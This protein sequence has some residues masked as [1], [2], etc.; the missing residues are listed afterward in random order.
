ML[1]FKFSKKLF[2]L[3]AISAGVLAA[4][5]YIYLKKKR[6]V[7]ELS[8]L[9]ANTD[10]STGAMS[11]NF[12]FDLETTDGLSG[13]EN[14]KQSIAHSGKMACNLGGGKEF[15][16]SVVRKLGDVGTFPIKRTAASI[17]IYPLSE[18]CNVVLTASISNSKNEGVFWDGKSTERMELP[19]NTWTKL[20][21]LYNFPVEKLN[22]DDV[23]QI[24]IWNKGKTD[25]IVDD[26]EVVYGESTERRG[27]HSMVDANLFYEKLFVGQRNKPPFPVIPFKK[28]EINNSDSTQLIAGNTNIDLSP[29]DEYLVGDFIE[30]KNNLDEL[31]YFKD[32][33]TFILGYSS[34]KEK[35]QILQET[36]NIIKQTAGNTI[37]KKFA[38]DFNSDGRADVLIINKNKWQLFELK[39]KAWNSI[40]NGNNG[41]LKADWFSD[42]NKSF[43]SDLFSLNNKDVLVQTNSSDYY[44]LQFNKTSGALEETKSN[45]S[46]AD[47]GLFNATSFI[48]PGDFTGR[49]MEELL[50]YDNEWR[51]DLK[52]L[53]KD[54]NGY[55]VVGTVDFTG[56]A[57]DYNP[58]YY[59]FLKIIPG[60]FTDSKKTS[61]LTIMRNCVDKDFNGMYCNTF[62][63]LIYLPNSVQLYTVMDACVW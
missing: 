59:E 20:N 16:F 60:R 39:D 34:E 22:A 23:L 14:I 21:A 38:G 37:A 27:S 1:P 58:K 19:A 12:F 62:E 4:G 43:V 36:E 51:F 49:G 33:K 54:K 40:A 7:P 32:N 48:Y 30:D 18:G 6:R 55:T 56:F 44:Q 46:K 5:V 9:S 28:L 57:N 24:N 52:L 45:I 8:A 29:N 47:S 17:W 31:L 25:V 41:E 53:E 15:G 3:L 61:L 63:N 2:F 11:T 10:N 42:S 35:F 13:T 50:K 26:L